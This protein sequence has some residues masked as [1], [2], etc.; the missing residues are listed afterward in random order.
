MDSTCELTER[1]QNLAIGGTEHHTKKILI[2]NK[3]YITQDNKLLHRGATFTR[4][5][6]SDP[7]PNQ[8]RPRTDPDPINLNRVWFKKYNRLNY[9]HGYKI[10]N[11]ISEP[12]SNRN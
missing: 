1:N 11:L 2:K 12:D 9:E 3:I 5:L 4:L 6:E 7:E 10:N 8:I